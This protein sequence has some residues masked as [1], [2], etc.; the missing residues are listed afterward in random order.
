[1]MYFRFLT[2]G[3]SVSAGIGYSE[4]RLNSRGRNVATIFL[5]LSSWIS[6]IVWWF[7]DKIGHYLIQVYAQSIHISN[8]LNILSRT[9]LVCCFLNVFFLAF[10]PLFRKFDWSHSSLWVVFNGFI[11]FYRILVLKSLSF[12]VIFI[13]LFLFLIFILVIGILYINIFLLY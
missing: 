7:I 13:H 8:L 5:Y 12:T 1:M 4:I 11:I 9:F 3:S 2:P 10:R 6:I